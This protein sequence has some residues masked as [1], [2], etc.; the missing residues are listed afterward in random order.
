MQ[1]H[2]LEGDK[3]HV[4]VTWCP[5]SPL[6][7]S[8]HTHTRQR[9]PVLHCIVR[10]ASNRTTLGGSRPIVCGFHKGRES[11]SHYHT[12]NQS[13]NNF[14]YIYVQKGYTYSNHG[15]CG[16]VYLR[17]GLVHATSDVA[18][19]AEALETQ[20]NMASPSHACLYSLI[21]ICRGNTGAELYLVKG[22]DLSL[23]PNP[24]TIFHHW[25]N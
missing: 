5:T 11:P 1:W 22:P 16:P 6:K 17:C 8:P 18:L 19:D 12:E 14:Q 7:N 25:D 9:W 10:G 4:T 3:R 21:N 15:S 24:R 13:I 2:K 23:V 20:V